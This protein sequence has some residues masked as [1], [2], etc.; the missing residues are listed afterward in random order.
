MCVFLKKK[1][2]IFT[3][4]EETQRPQNGRT[5]GLDCCLVHCQQWCAWL[6]RFESKSI[7][8]DDIWRQLPS[9]TWMNVFLV[10]GPLEGSYN[11]W[12]VWLSFRPSLRP[13]VRLAFS[14]NCI[15]TF[16]KILAWCSKSIWS[17]AWK[18]RIFQE[19]F[20]L[21]KKLGKWAQN[22]PKTGVF[23]I[24]WKF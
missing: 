13:S 6:G 4:F 9:G 20:L 15:I 8:N 17:C 24:Y 12:S 10:I 5:F 23:L 11:I 16:F 3:N 21:T 19:N 22:G 18:S 14:L 1:N 7:H 2:G